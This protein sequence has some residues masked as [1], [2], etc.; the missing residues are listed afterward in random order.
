MDIRELHN[1]LDSR[2][3]RIETKLD[4]YHGRLSKAEEALVWM[5]GH[6]KLVTAVGIAAFGSVL[7]GF[8]AKFIA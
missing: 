7:A 3:D 4:D 8:W 6:L 1:H 5:Q 2:L